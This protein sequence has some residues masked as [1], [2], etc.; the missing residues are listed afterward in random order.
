MFSA[1]ESI[2]LYDLLVKS[3]I[4]FRLYETPMQMD[5]YSIKT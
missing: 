3:S 1:I 5:K 4:P 2:P